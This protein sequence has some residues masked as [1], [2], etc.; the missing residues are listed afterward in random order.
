MGA[1]ATRVKTRCECSV[2]VP[3]SKTDIRPLSLRIDRLSLNLCANF[4]GQFGHRMMR[5]LSKSLTELEDDDWGP[6]NPGDTDLIQEVHAFRYKKL[7]QFSTHDVVRL[8]E[9]GVSLETVVP[10]A[11]EILSTDILSEG[12]YFPG[13]L[14]ESLLSRRIEADF[15][16]RNKLLRDELPRLIPAGPA[17][18]WD[19]TRLAD[20]DVLDGKIREFV[21]AQGPH[22]D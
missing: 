1:A 6:P 17:T 9:Q 21:R 2:C 14:L 4:D 15:W 8:V 7:G 11:L 10:L 18:S 19:A 22:N 12:I 13:D 20:G 5:D 16:K 3:K